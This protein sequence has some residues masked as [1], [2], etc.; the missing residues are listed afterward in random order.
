[1]TIKTQKITEL[2][3]RT[4]AGI[5]DIKKALTEAKGDEDKAIEILRKQGQKAARRGDFITRN[6]P[7]KSESVG[8][9]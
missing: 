4:G 3:Q 5:M 6:I 8:T 1:M 7:I 9:F 2:R